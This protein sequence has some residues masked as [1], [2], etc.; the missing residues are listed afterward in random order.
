MNLLSKDFIDSPS[1][2]S[3]LTSLGITGLSLLVLKFTSEGNQEYS[4]DVSIS[5]LSINE[6]FNQR[7]PLSN[8]LTELIS[9]DIESI[10]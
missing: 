9:S 4:K 6:G 10:E 3:H 2:V 8:H 7:L 5:S 1:D